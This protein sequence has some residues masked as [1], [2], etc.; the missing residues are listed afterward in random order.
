MMTIRNRNDWLIDYLIVD[1]SPLFEEGVN[2]HDGANV[3]GQIAPTGRAGQVLGRVQPVSVH[4]EVAVR[5]IHLIVT[6]QK[7]KHIY[8]NFF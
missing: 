2:A 4:H 8:F 6:K 5:Q 1:E 7:K 3:A